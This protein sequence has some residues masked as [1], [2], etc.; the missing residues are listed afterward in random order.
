MKYPLPILTIGFIAGIGI[1]K[2]IALPTGILLA[3]S[4][5][6]LI[7]MAIL[8]GPLTFS[9]SSFLIFVVLGTIIITPKIHPDI[10]HLI[11]HYD[12]Q[13]Y[14]PITGTLIY[15]ESFSDD[16]TRMTLSDVMVKEDNRWHEV[17]GRMR[18]TVYEAIRDLRPGDIVSFMGKVKIPRN[19][20]NP[21]GFDYE[22]Y[23]KRK[24]IFATSTLKGRD[25]LSV[26][27]GERSKVLRLVEKTKGR[28]REFFDTYTPHNE[29]A[30]LKALTLGERGD[31]PPDLLQSYY[32]TGTGHVL[33]ISGLHVGIIFIISS[34][35]L[36]SILVR[37]PGFNIRFNVK[38]WAIL[39]SSLPVI[40]YI[41]LSGFRISTVRAG[42]MIAAFAL[43]ILLGRVRDIMSTIS[44]AA[45]IILILYPTSLF[46]PSFQFSFVSVLSIVIIHPI[47]TDPV[48]KRFYSV[49]GVRPAL[50]KRLLFSIYSFLAVSLSALLGILPL[51]TYYFF[52]V[53]P[54]SLP[55]NLAV[56]PLLGFLA[57]PMALA[58]IPITL[59]SPN[60]SALLIRPAAWVVKLSN[61]IVLRATELSIGGS[62]VFPP[63]AIEIL[64][65]YTFLICLFTYFYGKRFNRTKI[66]RWSRL[67][68][69]SLV[70]LLVID[71][72]F[73]IHH[74]F[75]PHRLSV[76]FISVGQGDS[77][78]IKLPGG[79][80]MLV[81]GGGFYS[82][83]FDTGERVVGPYLLH[84]RIKR[85]DFVVLTHPEVD[86]SGGLGFVLENFDVGEL[87]ITEIGRDSGKIQHLLE[88]AGTRN[89][90]IV[91]VD[92]NTPNRI[93]NGVV[94]EFL[95]PPPASTHVKWIEG[96]YRKNTFEDIGHDYPLVARYT[97]L[98]K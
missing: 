42:L 72:S 8:R 78:L 17:P 84:E 45:L 31:I 46:E 26:H 50:P 16:T 57:T 88:I 1:G 4:G 87:W 15:S 79:K 38:T 48:R 63:R 37:I 95:N 34:L 30:I 64:I 20:N 61:E 96:C 52:R 65:Y 85:I 24:G 56:V 36:Y 75:D 44:A 98:C 6:L 68:I 60:I 5:V 43:S 76:T 62:L 54:F 92:E 89:I 51:S 39:L 29:G 70:F 14:M 73:W 74:R 90:P 80:T 69:V 77:T 55:L 25:F 27:K 47:I 41:L 35:I 33:A 23:L 19:F 93:I 86:H 58:I 10:T 53:T 49:K 40:S 11:S 7:T 94:I 66:V 91:V 82:G 13:E 67:L 21:G 12:S 81:D 18:L 3:V 83:R 71:I 9:I 97:R 32:R 59:F 2:L 28:I 22:L